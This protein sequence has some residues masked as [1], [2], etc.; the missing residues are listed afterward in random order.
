MPIT[1][2]F[3]GNLIARYGFELGSFNAHLQGAFVYSGSH[4]TLLNVEDNAVFGD[5][6]SSSYLDLSTG[7]QKNSW[8]IELYVKNALDEET[9]LGFGSEC[10]PLVC[11]ANQPYGGRYL[12]RTIGLKFS[13]EF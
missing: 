4:S 5:V 1:P 10:T 3:K 11:G 6:P 8:A 7:I 2:D 9:A 12:P 13:Q